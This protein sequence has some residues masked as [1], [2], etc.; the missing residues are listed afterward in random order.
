MRA[1]ILICLF[2]LSA[3]PAFAQASGAP[4]VRPRA[5]AEALSRMLVD[6]YPPSAL[7]ARQEGDVTL[8]MCVRA[9]GAVED[10]KVAQS[11]GVAELDAAAV[12]GISG[13]RFSPARDVSARAVDFC[14]PP[15]QLTIQWR[16]PQADPAGYP[17]PD[18]SSFMQ[19][20]QAE[21]PREAVAAGEEGFAEISACVSAQGVASDVRVERSSGS[22]RIDAAAVRL[23]SRLRFIMARDAEDRPI[24]WCEERFRITMGWDRRTA[25]LL[26]SVR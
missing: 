12:A 10:V 1:L 7:E 21:F 25:D 15:Y 26:S 11:S 16:V 17:Q 13:M 19:L 4:M 6:A 2:A 23:V 9:S 22:P 14:A 5:D 20:Y 18:F 24:A 8:S 3:A